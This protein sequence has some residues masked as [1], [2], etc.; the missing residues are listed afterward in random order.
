L[1][2]KALLHFKNNE[3]ELAIKIY[4][5]LVLE[6]ADKHYVWQEFSDCIVS[7][8]PLKIGMLSKALSLEKNEDF[9]GDIHLDLAKV[10][11]DENLLENALIEL[12]AYKKHRELKGWKLSS[13][14]DELHKKASSVKQSLKD[15]RELYKKYIPFAENFAY[16]DFDWT[17][18][19]LVDKWKDDKGKERLT[20]TD[21][22]TIEFAIG[23]NRFE[24]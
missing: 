14:F 2:E 15:N 10:L 19:V 4:K 18:V 23:K 5:Q 24:V 11:I 13:A 7:D 12:E 1:R 9:L 8:N 21:G 20:F 17:E 6:L 3:L 16:A 22:K